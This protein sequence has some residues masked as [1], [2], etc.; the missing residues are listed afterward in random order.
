MGPGASMDMGKRRILWI[1]IKTEMFETVI[2]ED[3]N[4]SQT[5]LLLLPH[6]N[7][8]NGVDVQI[9]SLEIKKKSVYC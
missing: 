4:F 2:C 7:Y 6:R 5:A 1:K 9:L 3:L 8:K